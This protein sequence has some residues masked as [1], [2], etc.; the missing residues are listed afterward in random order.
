MKNIDHYTLQHE[1]DYTKLNEIDKKIILDYVWE[2]MEM[3]DMLKQWIKD[4]YED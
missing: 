3:M 2:D 1:I 4:T